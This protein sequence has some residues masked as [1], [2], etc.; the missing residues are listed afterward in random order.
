MADKLR[1]KKNR[2]ST[3]SIGSLLSAGHDDR[4]DRKERKR[5]EKFA[6]HEQTLQELRTADRRR[7]YFR[8]ASHRQEVI[9]GPEVR[10]HVPFTPCNK[11]SLPPHIPKRVHK[12]GLLTFAFVPR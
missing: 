4:K 12:R 2:L 7:A 10:T 11:P 3:A 6:K 8:D 1:S 5:T 9:F